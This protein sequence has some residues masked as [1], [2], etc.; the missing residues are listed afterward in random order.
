V[1]RWLAGL[2]ALCSHLACALDTGGTHASWEEFADLGRVAVVSSTRLPPRDLLLVLD[3]SSA[4]PEPLV[5]L[6]RQGHLVAHIPLQ[7]FLDR[8]GHNDCLSAVTLLDVFSQHLQTNYRFSHYQRPLLVGIDAAAAFALATLAQAPNGIFAAGIG[9]GFQPELTLPAPLCPAAALAIETAGAGQAGS[10]HFRLGAIHPAAPWR[11]LADA[12]ALAAA[13]DDLTKQPAATAGNRAAP[14]DDLPLVELPA[15]GRSADSAPADTFV[16]LLS[17]DGGWANID[18]DIGETLNRT[19]LPVV[20]WNSLQYF[21]RKKSPEQAG[22]DLARVIAHYQQTWRR[23][24]VLLV[25]Y[26]LG[27]DVL[28]FMINRLPASARPAI[29][30]TALLS[31]GHKVDFEFHV[32][33]WLGSNST[34][35][36]PIAP[37]LAKL[38]GTPLLCIFGRDD[39]DSLC[40]DHPTG[41]ETRQLP[42]DHHFNGDYQSA[43]RLILEQLAKTRN[44]PVDVH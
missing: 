22:A 33:D 28:P 1:K 5:A 3:A 38:A 19:G 31:L 26:S 14:V 4:L 2:L 43:A 32:S 13:I 39:D 27:A 36:R 6:A 41:L 12:G 42:G 9:I 24:K 20:G 34:Q 16:V 17:G 44:H 40:A 8:A 23:P 10:Q 35:A 29:A 18:K 21:W 7:Q 25:G 15:P 37:E 11:T 30:A